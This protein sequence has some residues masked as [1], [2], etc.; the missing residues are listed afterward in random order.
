MS[1]LSISQLLALA[2]AAGF[3]GSDLATAVAIALA[4]SGGN[5]QAYN[6]EA[7]AGAPQGYGSFGLWQI[8]LKAHPE[9]Q[10]QNLFDPATNA[11]AA[12]AVYSAAGSSFSPWSTFTSGIYSASLEAVNSVLSASPEQTAG[13]PDTGSLLSMIAV[14]GLALWALLKFFG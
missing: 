11:A 13:A 6:P 4:E 9:F 7:A 2:S 5:P 1:A 12:Y 10:G 8:Y 3:S 14:G